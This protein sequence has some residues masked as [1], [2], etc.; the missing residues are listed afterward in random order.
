MESCSHEIMESRNRKCEYSSTRSH[1]HVLFPL[2]GVRNRRRADRT[3][4]CAPPKDFSR[5]GIQRDEVTFLI[6]GE[7]QT[8]LGCENSRP[9]L[10]EMWELP[11]LF[12]A[13]R[14]ECHYCSTSSVIG[15]NRFRTSTPILFPRCIFLRFR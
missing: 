9:G 2:H 11:L 4:E 12:T 15:P 10:R 8:T 13:Q 6:S 5:A 7:S 14:V 1:G 3:S